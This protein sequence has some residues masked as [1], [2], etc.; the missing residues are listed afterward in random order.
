MSESEKEIDYTEKDEDE[1]KEEEISSDDE[2]NEKME[3]DTKTLSISTLKTRFIKK[4][5]INLQPSYQRK[6]CWSFDKQLLFIDTI[7]RGYITPL[8]ILSKIKKEKGSNYEYECVDGQHRLQVLTNFLMLIPIK[9]RKT[10]KKNAERYDFVH[11]NKEVDGKKIRIFYEKVNDDRERELNRMYNNRWRYMDETEKSEFNEYNMPI[12][13]IQNV[14]SEKTK[15]EMFNRLQNGEKIISSIRLKNMDNNI[16]DYLRK[17]KLLEETEI[18]RYNKIRMSERR[19]DGYDKKLSGYLY[20]MIRI[21]MMYYNIDKED[22]EEKFIN[23]MDLNIKKSIQNNTE[24]VRIEKGD[25]K[26]YIKEI[27][28]D[29]EIIKEKIETTIPWQLYL[30]ISR[31]KK[32]DKKIIRSNKIVEVMRDYNNTKY[33]IKIT[34]NNKIYDEIKNKLSNKVVIEKINYTSKNEMMLNNL[35]DKLN[36]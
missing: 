11:I 14:V 2:E 29:Y 35:L 13:I 3:I 1:E 27:Q 18:D 34:G 16:L 6:F 33:D 19:V 8:I 7:S 12:T 26:K 21:I 10:T 25:I 22:K 30:I 24:M 15:R 36:E 20:F 32:E 9:R 23:F 31:L 5:N 28:E 4:G 17:N